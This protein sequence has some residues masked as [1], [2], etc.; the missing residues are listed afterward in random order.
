MVWG[1]MLS[2]T[3]YNYSWLAGLCSYSLKFVILSL[4]ETSSE[5]CQMSL[6]YPGHVHHSNYL[7]SSMYI[8]LLS[9]ALNDFKVT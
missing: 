9:L 1:K 8:H 5:A 3:S 6:F 4:M 7:H 2:K